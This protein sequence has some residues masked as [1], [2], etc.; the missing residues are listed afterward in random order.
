MSNK[1]FEHYEMKKQKMLKI[2][3]HIGKIFR[4]QN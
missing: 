2:N 1:E 3:G 4:N